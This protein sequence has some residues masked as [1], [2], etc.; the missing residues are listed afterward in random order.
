MFSFG[1]SSVAN[2]TEDVTGSLEKEGWNAGKTISDPFESQWK[3]EQYSILFFDTEKWYRALEHAE[4]YRWKDAVEIWISLLDTRDMLKRA[5][6][7]YNIAV[8]AYMSGD[9]ELA[10]KWLDRS[11]TDNPL[12]LSDGLRR[13][14]KAR[15]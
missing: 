8:A 3:H 5:C 1:G 2:L 10:L 12:S 6:A 9:M 4:Q 13:R 14:I 7:E 15:M 11:D